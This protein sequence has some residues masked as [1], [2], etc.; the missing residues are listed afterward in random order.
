MINDIKS[1]FSENKLAI[2]LSIAILFISLILGYILAPSLHSYLNPVVEDLTQKVESGVITLTFTDIFFNNFRIIVEMFVF[3][4]ACCFSVLMLAF[5]GFFVGYYVGT[6]DDVVRVLLLII[7]HGI[8]EFSSII[9]ACASG[10]I[11]FNFIYSFLKA[12][13]FDKN[14][15]VKV[16]LKNSYDASSKK[17]KH[18]IIVFLIASVLMVIAG[19]IEVYFTVPI[20]EFLI[21]FL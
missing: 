20:A 2:C 17:L 5:N 13:W 19:I 12:L 21:K 16:S 9:L 7:P 1:A 10:L 14:E 6:A 8:F 3:G 15:S 18:A 4:V 11:L